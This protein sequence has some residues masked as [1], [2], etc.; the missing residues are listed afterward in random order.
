[1]NLFG[2]PRM[3][4]PHARGRRR[5]LP[6]VVGAAAIAMVATVALAFHRDMA[7]ARAHTQGRS[8]V[9]DSPWGPIEYAEVGSGPPVLMIHGSGGGFDQGLDF[10][11]PLAREGVRIIAPSRFGYLRSAMPD[12]A[13][14][15]MQADALDWLMNRLGIDQAVIIGGSA[16]A[17]SATQLALRHPGRC[18]GLVLV[19]PALH[20]PDRLPGA[21]AAPDAGTQRMINAALGSDF[22]FWAGIRGAPDFMTRMVLA[23]DPATVKAAEASERRRASDVMLHILPVS[24]RREGLLMDSATAGAPPDWPVE[25]IACPTLVAGARGD[26]YETDKAAVHVAG[27]IPEA[28]LVMYPDG[29]H[30]WIGHDAELWR[31]VGAFAKGLEPD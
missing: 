31:T 26:L 1:M 15:E 24:A 14:V 21:N 7:E 20:A 16:G 9:V 18:R 23:T 30:L 27:R 8:R 5:W 13:T 6:V 3:R 28:R 4:R 17:L 29:G 2:E 10:S 22:L 11:A 19:V 12:G 25:R